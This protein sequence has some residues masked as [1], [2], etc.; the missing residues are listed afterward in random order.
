MRRTKAQLERELKGWRTA[1]KA[2][3]RIIDEQAV[4]LADLRPVKAQLKVA[5][6]LVVQH[7]ETIRKQH[8]VIKGLEQANRSEAAA[9]RSDAQA[10]TADLMEHKRRLL[11]R[12]GKVDALQDLVLLAMRHRHH[13]PREE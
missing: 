9:L 3:D 12:A 8:E 6:S 5:Q 13:V 2:N 7:Q 11:R 4:E 10:L 1:A